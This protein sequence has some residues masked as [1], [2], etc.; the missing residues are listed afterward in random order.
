[1]M[2]DKLIL[3]DVFKTAWRALKTQFWLLVG[4]P[5]G[6]TIIYSLLLIYAFLEKGESISIGGLIVSFLNLLL[7]NLFMM[8]YLKNCFQ[9]LEGE[10]PQFSAY[11]QN[12]GK[13]LSFLVANILCVIMIIIGLALLIVPGIYLALRLQFFYAYMAD[14]NTGVIESFK[15]SWDITKGQ[16]LKLFLL[17]LIMVLITIVGMIAL[18]AGVF[19]AIPL[20]TLMYVCVFRKLTTRVALL[21]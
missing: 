14:D 15:R 21:Q 7:L 17:T 6:F 11:G 5:I 16:S 3:S 8:G 18:L 20:T 10:E 13:L 1:M 12:F 4:L 19:I 9:S 2:E